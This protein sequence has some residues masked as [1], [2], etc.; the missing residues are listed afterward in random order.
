MSKP[1]N[2]SKQIN[3]WIACHGST[4]DA[5]N[6]AIGQLEISR[7]NLAAARRRIVRLEQLLEMERFNVAFVA[8]HSR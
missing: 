8:Q 6:V 3:E 7:D 2:V 1:V 5:L 4:R